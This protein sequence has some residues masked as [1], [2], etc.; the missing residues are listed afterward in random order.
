MMIEVGKLTAK[1][2]WILI[3]FKALLQY[4]A[5]EVFL[6][7]SLLLFV[8]FLVGRRT[9]RMCNV[10]VLCGGKLNTVTHAQLTGLRHFN[11]HTCSA[12]DT[13]RLSRRRA[14][15]TM[16]LMRSHR[17]DRLTARQPG[18]EA[19]RQGGQSIQ[20][21]ANEANFDELSWMSKGNGNSNSN[22]N[23]N[24]NWKQKL[25]TETE[26]E[27]LKKLETRVTLLHCVTHWNEDWTRRG[28]YGNWNWS[29]GESSST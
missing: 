25:K 20:V 17:P 9:R 1:L 11:W 6:L 18:S 2:V 10:A 29:L 5:L 14:M 28:A 12:L 23:R 19:A 24:F 8:T 22:S 15:I 4:F 3:G 16:T 13:W 21:L 27:L 26:T 7:L